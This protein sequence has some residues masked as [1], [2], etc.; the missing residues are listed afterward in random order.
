MY[1]VAVEPRLSR[2]RIPRDPTVREPEI[3]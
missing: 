3:Q 1:W 2:S